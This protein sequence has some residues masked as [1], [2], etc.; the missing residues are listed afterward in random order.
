MNSSLYNV[1]GYER[2]K[3][4]RV[5]SD[6]PAFQQLW[7]YPP[8]TIDL[9]ENSTKEQIAAAKKEALYFLSGVLKNAYRKNE[10]LLFKDG[11]VLDFDNILI[12][13]AA[14]KKCIEES[15][16]SVRFVLYPTISNYLPG[17]GM[18]FRLII[19]TDR[20]YTEEENRNLLQNIIDHIGQPCDTASKT[21]SQLMGLPVL[22]KLSPESLI[23]KQEGEPLK[24]DEWLFEPMNKKSD[25]EPVTFTGE[26][27][28]EKAVEMVQ[29]YVDRVGDKLLDR[30]YYLN[31]Y[32]NIRYAYQ[33]GEIDLKTVETCLTILALGDD[34]WASHNIA[35]F[36]RD[37]G[38]VENGTPFTSF[39]GWVINDPMDD[40]SGVDLG[41]S[42]NQFE[43]IKQM[44]TDLLEIYNTA[45]ETDEATYKEYLK[46]IRT[47]NPKSKY[48]LFTILET[49]G[50]LK[51][52]MLKEVKD[53][54]KDGV[55]VKRS[56]IKARAIANILKVHCRFYRLIVQSEQDSYPFIMYDMESGLYKQS[57][58]FLKQLI[59]KIDYE[60][61]E[62]EC[63]QVRHF[64]ST[65]CKKIGK[66]KDENLIVCKNGIFNR[67][68][69]KLEPFS[70]NFVFLTGI[71]TKYVE[72]APE[73][74]YDDGWSLEKWI[75]QLSGGDRT[76]ELNFWR[77]IYHAN[78]PNT[79]HGKSVFFY[80]EEGRTGKG[81][82]KDLI[83]NM[84]G[85]QNHASAN[86]K[87]FDTRWVNAELYG[88]TFVS[89]DEND[90][91]KFIDGENFKT[92]VSNDYSSIEQ[93]G[94]KTFTDK[95]DVF[96]L[97]LMNEKPNF[98]KFN[99]AEKRRILL[100]EFNNGA[101]TEERNNPNV[102]NKYVKDE[103]LHEY[104]LFKVMNMEHVEFEDTE[105]SKNLIY[106]MELKRKPVKRYWLDYKDRFVSLRIPIS[107]LYNHG[108]T[109]YMR[110]EGVKD[111]YVMALNTFI[112]ELKKEMGD[113]WEYTSRKKP[114]D[115]FKFEDIT[116]FEDIEPWPFIWGK[117]DK[118]RN[119]RLIERKE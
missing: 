66:T 9:D 61:L 55:T 17:K 96:I 81:T 19:E 6:K 15:L 65:E 107:F 44:K 49:E 35:H 23:T 40:F 45:E 89:G 113:E 72:N 78:N 46:I 108:F 77:C 101:Y 87:R 38:K 111:T 3:M 41:D 28:H 97:Q 24:V 4:H 93:K 115:Y 69:R 20:T 26:L 60:K 112:D 12:G 75:R 70:P 117:E 63:K 102:K 64:L 105:E 76:K 2:G 29:G 83:V 10:N 95:L 116:L 58:D 13:Y 98:N 118:N 67:G 47:Y 31:P 84:V 42:K 90:D 103:K 109:S 59:L 54:G 53:S 104:I 11:I 18:R 56:R 33:Q 7:E 119:Q 92:A 34:N 14:F 37:K 32:M 39:F 100:V 52:Q 30:K 79:E 50:I 71:N 88:K 36:Y 57:F 25:F 94:E 1:K 80:S 91:V 106:Q 74:I 68:T 27:T 48:E 22:N 43:R 85:E 8:L 86:L 114:G 99:S 82:F 51:R 21:W 16:P 73:P 110:A 5:Q 62:H